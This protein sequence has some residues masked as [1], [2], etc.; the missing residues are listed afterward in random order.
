MKLQGSCNTSEM[1]ISTKSIK[2]LA[3]LFALAGVVAEA[4][5]A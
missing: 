3:F 1:K 4:D 2:L 5:R